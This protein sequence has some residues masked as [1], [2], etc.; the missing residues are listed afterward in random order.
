MARTADD[1]ALLLA[2]IAG[3]DDA[4]PAAE[5]V[6]LGEAE[7]DAGF[8][9]GVCP[10]LHLVP[11]DA[12][13][14]RAFDDA[15][16][17]FRSLGAEIVEVAMPEAALAYPTFVMTQRPEAL[18][19]HVERG[20][21]P[22][23]SGEYGDDVRARLQAAEEVTIRDY[24]RA[25]ADRQRVRAAFA[26]VFREV[27]VLLTPVGGTA[28]P[29]DEV[30][31]AFRDLVM[32]YTVPQDLTGLPACALR[33]GFDALGLPVGVQLT[34][35]PWSEPRVLRAAAAFYAATPTVQDV[36]PDPLVSV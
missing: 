24:L 13:V 31:E 26:R 7:L 32:P 29:I 4:D 1:A 6:P 30:G 19:T 12:D 22:A 18:Q 11:L 2:A 8:R 16:A 33:A 27:D 5:D 35:S 28:P 36:W 3:A 34:G 20:L 9:V 21:F 15:V 10:D 17:A 25:A 14:A 23:R